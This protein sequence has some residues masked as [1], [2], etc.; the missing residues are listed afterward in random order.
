M[1]IIYFFLAVLFLDFL[2]MFLPINNLLLPLDAATIDLQF[3]IPIGR[4][5]LSSPPTCHR[6]STLKLTSMSATTLRYRL[7]QT[8]PTPGWWW[9]TLTFGRRSAAVDE[10]TFKAGQRIYPKYQARV[11]TGEP[12]ITALRLLP[13]SFLQADGW[14]ENQD[15]SVDWSVGHRPSSL[16]GTRVGLANLPI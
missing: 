3:T 14:R 13:K 10:D 8:C 6:E 9:S 15:N 4:P 5:V 7:R 16:N 1:K 11:L 12:S 2:P